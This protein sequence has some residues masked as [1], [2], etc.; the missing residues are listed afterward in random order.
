MGFSA[1]LAGDDGAAAPPRVDAEHS[2]SASSSVSLVSSRA[3]LRLVV[4]LGRLVIGS[5]VLKPRLLGK[6]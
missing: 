5:R 6:L 4:I 3:Q 2:E 1:G